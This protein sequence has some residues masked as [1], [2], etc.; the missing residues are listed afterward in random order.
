ML[1][2]TLLLPGFD[3]ITRNAAVLNGRA[4]IAGTRVAVHVIATELSTKSPAAVLAI[5]PYLDETDL[6][7]AKN[8]IRSLSNTGAGVPCRVNPQGSSDSFPRT[9]VGK[10]A[11]RHI[12]QSVRQ[13]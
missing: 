12:R 10:H 4:C 13:T 6:I 7:Q 11:D 3:R 8:Y 1:D 9:P 2:V 5:Y